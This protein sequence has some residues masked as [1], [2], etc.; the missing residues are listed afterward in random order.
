MESARV[1]DGDANM[2]FAIASAK[3]KHMRILVVDESSS[4]RR[5]HERLF[6]QEGHVV[7]CAG[8]GYEGLNVIKKAKIEE[9]YGNTNAL[10]DVVTISHLMAGMTGPQTIANMRSHGFKGV[11]MV[12]T[13]ESTTQE[14]R[15]MRESGADCVVAKPLKIKSF[16]RALRG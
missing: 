3:K 6:Q 9:A 15:Q 13:S 14:I 2:D 1:D 4:V 16:K 7:L 8:S 11:V 5:I 10:F 12:V